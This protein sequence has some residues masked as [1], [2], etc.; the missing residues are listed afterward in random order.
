LALLLLQVRMPSGMQGAKKTVMEGGVRNF[1]AVRGPGVAQGATSDAL[2]GLIDITP[3]IVEL[4][5]IEQVRRNMFDVFV[6]C[7]AAGDCLLLCSGVAAPALGWHR[8]SVYHAN[9]AANIWHT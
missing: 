8:L 6:C 5:G 1:L 3:T 4:A 9:P 7:I 2:T